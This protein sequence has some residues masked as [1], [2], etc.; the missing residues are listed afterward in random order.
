LRRWTQEHR[1]RQG[2]DGEQTLDPQLGALAKA[3][4]GKVFIETAGG[5]LVERE[6]LEER[7][8]R[9]KSSTTA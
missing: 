4:C 3:E 9:I 6:P 8:E 2:V 5:V 7:L 1:V